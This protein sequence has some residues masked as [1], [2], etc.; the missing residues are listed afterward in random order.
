MKLVRQTWDLLFGILLIGVAPLCM[1]FLPVVTLQF[2]NLFWHFE[3]PSRAM[4][5]VTGIFFITAF[6]T[7]V[8]AIWWRSRHRMT[9]RSLEFIEI[10]AGVIL[11]LFLFAYYG[12]TVHSII[13]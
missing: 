13:D 11:G 3:I 6:V 9:P 10:V 7:F 2:F 12:I 8:L 4:G 1:L 5:I